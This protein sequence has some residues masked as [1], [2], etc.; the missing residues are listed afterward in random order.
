[1]KKV[2]KLKKE[3]LELYKEA[4]ATLEEDE[5]FESDKI[6][7]DNLDWARLVIVESHDGLG[8]V[9]VMVENEH[10]TQF[11]VSDLSNVELNIF[12][13]NI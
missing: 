1:M 2:A 11:E 4:K 8:T 9:E 3:F 5:V 6:E 12:L 7:L 10:G 13:D